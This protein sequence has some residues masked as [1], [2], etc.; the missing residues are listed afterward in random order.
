MRGFSG[1]SHALEMLA[2]VCGADDY[3]AGVATASI[4]C[5]GGA[6]A[7]ELAM[8]PTPTGCATTELRRKPEWLES[9]FPWKQKSLVVN[10]RTLA[11]LDEGD[12]QGRPVLLLSGN[13]TWGFLYRD[14]VEPLERAGCRVIVPDWVGAGYSDHPRDDRALTMAHHIADL[15]SLLDQLELRD[16]VVVGQDW[17]G[18]QGVGGRPSAHRAAWCAGAHEHLAVYG[19]G[20]EVSLVAATVDDL[21]RAAGGPAV[22]ETSQG[23]LPRRPNRPHSAR[24]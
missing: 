20:R 3:W 15:V 10:G 8:S 5:G 1:A 6:R 11:Y 12:P 14:F 13:P 22:D 23:A 17:G 24:A 21:A 18:P 16:F 9:L 4:D 2:G 7:D 19:P